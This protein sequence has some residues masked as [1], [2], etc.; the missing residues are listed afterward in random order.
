MSFTLATG[1]VLHLGGASQ[2]TPTDSLGVVSLAA[3]IPQL[4]DKSAFLDSRAALVNPTN[5]LSIKH[6]IIE[7]VSV[8]NAVAAGTPE[9]RRMTNGSTPTTDR[10]IRQLANDLFVIENNTEAIFNFK[11]FNRSAG[12]MVVEVEVFE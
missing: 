2:T 4:A 3:G 10:G 6:A 7:I 1:T 9:G 11:L 12:N 8:A 5:A